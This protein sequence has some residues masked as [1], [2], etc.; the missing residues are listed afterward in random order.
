VQNLD[1]RVL[2]GTQT[3]NY[4]ESALLRKFGFVLDIEAASTYPE[5]I[6]PSYSYR[7]APFKHSQWIHRSGVV[8]AQVL[9]GTNGFLFLTNRL[10][11][12]GR[13]SLKSKEMRPSALA[14][15][16]MFAIDHFCN[17]PEALNGFYKEE[18][19]LLAPI[20]EDPPPFQL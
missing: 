2:E 17:D 7:R 3:H 15:D 9:G 16:V 19:A 1:K 8:F 4:F 13:T 6:D 12:H 14:D 11:S 5:Q 18:I 20:P 10:I